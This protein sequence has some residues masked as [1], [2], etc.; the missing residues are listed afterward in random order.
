MTNE[1][2]EIATKLLTAGII[3]G[4][5][6]AGLGAVG[7]TILPSGSGF[8]RGGLRGLGAGA[9]IGLGSAIAPAIAEHYGHPELKELSNLLGGSLGGVLGYQVMKSLTQSEDEKLKSVMLD[10][11]TKQKEKD[12]A[13]EDE[14]F[15]LG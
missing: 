14:N 10:Y 11:Y 15:Q 3:P 2:K 12:E 7:G 4:G 13:E 8:V 6:F 9:G 5:I 1:Q